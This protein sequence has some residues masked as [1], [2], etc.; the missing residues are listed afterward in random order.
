M[1]SEG[2]DHAYEII[3]MTVV[4]GVGDAFGFDDQ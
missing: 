1:H 2:D 4:F 3:E